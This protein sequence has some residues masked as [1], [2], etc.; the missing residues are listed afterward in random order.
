MIATAL[1][2]DWRFSPNAAVTIAEK[3]WHKFTRDIAGR[4]YSEGSA[5]KTTVNKDGV[6][7]LNKSNSKTLTVS[8]AS[9]T[10]DMTV[11]DIPVVVGTEVKTARVRGFS[12]KCV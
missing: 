9:I 7:V 1:G 11:R 5:S 3:P 2:P 10:A 12:I 6:T 4:T 8:P